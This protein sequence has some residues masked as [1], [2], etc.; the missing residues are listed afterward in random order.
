M[1]F[2]PSIFSATQTRERHR[3]VVA[4]KLDNCSGYFPQPLSVQFCED[5]AHVEHPVNDGVRIEKI[6]ELAS[7]RRCKAAIGPTVSEVYQVL[8]YVALCGSQHPIQFG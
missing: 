6:H 8:V 7:V 3:R 1:K 5:N 2:K 4:P